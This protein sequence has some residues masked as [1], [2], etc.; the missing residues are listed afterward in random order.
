MST[1]RFGVTE[2]RRPGTVLVDATWFMPGAAAQTGAQL[3]DARRLA[4]AVYFDIDAVSDPTSALPHMAPGAARFQRWLSAYGLSAE[5]SFIIYDQNSGFASARVWWTFLRF[6]LQARIL[7]GGFAAALKAG[8][9]VETGPPPPRNEMPD[10]DTSDRYAGMVMHDTTMSWADVL[11]HSKAGDALIVDARPAGRFEGRDREPRE[12]LASGHIPGSVNLPFGA[13]LDAD[14]R[15][16]QGAALKRVLPD[17]DPA[18]RVVT[19]CGSGVTAAIL[20]AAF[21]EVGFH[22]VWLYDGSW[23]EWA[24]RGDLPVATGPA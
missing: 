24:G 18:R 7:D 19:T 23:T 12:G 13:L 14:G 11:T 4:G 15:M 21:A 10:A 16:K 22:D 20:Y 8:W 17:V 1:V 2:P 9:Q 6:G 3:F 5:E